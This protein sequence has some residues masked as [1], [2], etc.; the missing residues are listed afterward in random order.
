MRLEEIADQ[1]IIGILDDRRG[2]LGSTDG[3]DAYDVSPDLAWR[4]ELRF[5]K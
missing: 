2:S 3:R 4:G 5:T 1:Q